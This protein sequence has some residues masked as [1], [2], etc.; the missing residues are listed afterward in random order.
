MTNYKTDEVLYR[1]AREMARVMSKSP[2]GNG[3]VFHPMISHAEPETRIFFERRFGNKPSQEGCYI[4][5]SDLLNAET[6]FQ[7]KIQNLEWFEEIDG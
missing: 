3:A 5:E 1:Y 4:T 2:L 7:D 6:S